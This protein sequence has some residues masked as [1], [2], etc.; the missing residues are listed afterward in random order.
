MKKHKYLFF[1]FFQSDLLIH[2]RS[3]IRIAFRNQFEGFVSTGLTNLVRIEVKT[4]K[5]AT[6]VVL[7]VVLDDTVVLV[8][9]TATLLE[10]RADIEWEIIRLAVSVSLSTDVTV[11][12]V[13]RSDGWSM[14]TVLVFVI[15]VCYLF[16]ICRRSLKLSSLKTI[17]GCASTS[18][19]ELLTCIVEWGKCMKSS[20][21]PLPTVLCW[22]KYNPVIGHVNCFITTKYQA[23]T[24]SPIQIWS[25]AVFVS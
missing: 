22:M 18:L 2:L 4:A 6:G 21:V 1:W 7:F 20:V 12:V 10:T 13:F 24:Y 17:W 23:E 9:L 15:F 11:L 19:L 14:K 25:L 3:Q 16:V 5:S 8:I